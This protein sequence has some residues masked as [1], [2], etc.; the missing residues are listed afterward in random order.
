MVGP[1]SVM[2]AFW[3]QKFKVSLGYRGRLCTV[4]RYPLE[5]TTQTWA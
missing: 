5:K 2:Q 3:R 4:V 1:V